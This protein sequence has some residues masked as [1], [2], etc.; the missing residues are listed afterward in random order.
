MKK[1]L[2]LL[3]SVLLVFT[4]VACDKEETSEEDIVMAAVQGNYDAMNTEDIDAYMSYINVDS[5]VFEATEQQIEVMFEVYDVRV[6]ATDME[7]IE[8]EGDVARVRV[9]QETIN[10]NDEAFQD[11]K[12]TIVHTLNK[13]DGDWKITTSEVETTEIL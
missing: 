13:V 4:F 1:I 10:E 7:V 2:L 12:S 8:I 3:L 6:K 5:T 9:V 11:N